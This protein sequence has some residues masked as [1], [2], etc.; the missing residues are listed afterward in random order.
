MSSQKASEARQSARR[1]ASLNVIMQ[2]ERRGDVAWEALMAEYLLFATERYALPILGPLASAL[3]LGAVLAPTDPVLAGDL[4]V[5]PPT[6]GGE[7]PVRFALTTEAGLND[8]LA[9]PFVYLALAALGGLSG[10][11]AFNWLS[12]DVAYRIAAG[13]VSGV[14]T[15]WLVV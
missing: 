4:Q 3:L 11:E 13:A 8:G 1:P 12:Y 7:H 10:T 14:L 9:F 15:G 2:A 6:E 5:G